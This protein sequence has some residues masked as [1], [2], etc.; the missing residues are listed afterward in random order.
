M[1]TTLRATC[2]WLFF[3]SSLTYAEPTKLIDFQQHIQPILQQRCL[4]CH[5]PKQAK[6][7]F[8]VDQRESIDAYIDPGSADGSSLWTDYLRTDDPDM[9]M[10]PANEGHSGG[11][12]VGELLLIKAWIDEGAEGHWQADPAQS[13]SIPTVP[14]SD[15]AKWWAFQGLFHPATVHF[16]VA[17]LSVSALFVLLSFLNRQS[18]EP[19]AYHC[20]WL[21]ALGAVVACSAGWSYAVYRGYGEGVGFD[22]AASAI[23]R[24]RWAG[25]FVAVLG[26]LTIPLA[27]SVRRGAGLNKRIVWLLASCILA[28][29]VSLSGYQGGELTYGEDHYL[30]YFETLF[31]PETAETSQPDAADA[32]S[33]KVNENTAEANNS[34][35][36][37][38]Q[39][40]VTDQPQADQ[41]EAQPSDAETSDAG[42][43]QNNDDK[44]EDA[45]E[46][47]AEPSPADD[48][49]VATPS[50]ESDAGN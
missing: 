6:N 38:T 49:P 7:D 16:P 50:T 43:Q 19:V 40:T 15:L 2:L 22:L 10:P 8:R 14:S 32:E 3:A 34:A 27:R 29:A 20:L 28:A 12:P 18:F 1:F 33:M 11:L 46:N 31:P 35:P 37:E 4:E 42:A 25:V 41:Q 5:G 17:L 47:K 26:L 44:P 21:G 23:D 30:R 9:L 13:E 36:G 24:H 45:S 48:E 39:E